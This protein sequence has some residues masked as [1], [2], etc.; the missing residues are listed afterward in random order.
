M[1][2]ILTK[3]RETGGQSTLPLVL[4]CLGSSSAAMLSSAYSRIGPDRK[5]AISSQAS[6]FGISEASSFRISQASFAFALAYLILFMLNCQPTS[7]CSFRSSALMG[8]WTDAWRVNPAYASMVQLGVCAL[9]YKIFWKFE[10]GQLLFKLRQ[11]TFTIEPTGAYLSTSLCSRCQ[12]SLFLAFFVRPMAALVPT[13]QVFFMALIFISQL[14]LLPMTS[15]LVLTKLRFPIS[16]WTFRCL[17]HFQLALGALS[18]F[19]QM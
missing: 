5:Y 11:Q 9:D 13:N 4:P 8:F 2:H 16:F 18:T 10:T 1:V 7:Q 3:L 17:Y 6:V 19:S 14:L 15:A 12:L